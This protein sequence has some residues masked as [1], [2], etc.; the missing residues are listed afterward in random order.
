MV[1]YPSCESQIIVEELLSLS[2]NSFGTNSPITYIYIKQK[3]VFILYLHK[4]LLW[5]TLKNLKNISKNYPRCAN[6]VMPPFIIF[7]F[8]DLASSYTRPQHKPIKVLSVSN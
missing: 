4:I 7:Q 2:P 8:D 6:S 5:Q 3:T 1:L